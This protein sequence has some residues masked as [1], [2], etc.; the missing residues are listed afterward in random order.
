M[1]GG[2]ELVSEWEGD[3][4]LVGGE[5]AV[6]GERG[7][8]KGLWAL[9]Q[10]SPEGGSLC[11]VWAAGPGTPER[12]HMNPLLRCLQSVLVPKRL[13]CGG[14]FKS[15]SLSRGLELA[16]VKPTVRACLPNTFTTVVPKSGDERRWHQPTVGGSKGLGDPQ[17]PWGS[18]T[19][20]LVPWPG[21]A[22]TQGSQK[23][24]APGPASKRLRCDQAQWGCPPLLCAHLAVTTSAATRSTPFAEPTPVIL[25]QQR[26]F[27][28]LL[29]W[30]PGPPPGTGDS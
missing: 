7:E 16:P 6:P 30:T 23:A 21:L 3:D 20:W 4:T 12:P 25:P 9:V 24:V 10:P 19:L 2:R 18:F 26:A 28:S 8:G 15:P 1:G 17:G 5:E 14:P 13:C 11:C 27:G 29:G 22:K